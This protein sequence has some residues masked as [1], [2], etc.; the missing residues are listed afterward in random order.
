MS[1][2]TGNF[3]TLVDA[4]ETFGAD[5]MRLGLAVGIL[6]SIIFLGRR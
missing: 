3:M 1:K 2:S 4:I 6:F 5:G